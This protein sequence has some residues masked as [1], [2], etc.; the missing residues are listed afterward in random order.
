MKC[1]KCEHSVGEHDANGCQ[2]VDRPNSMDLVCRCASTPDGIE[3]DLLARIAVL[4]KMLALQLE[5]SLPPLEKSKVLEALYQAKAFV[6]GFED[7]EAQEGV[8]GILD[9][10][11]QAIAEVEQVTVNVTLKNGR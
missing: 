7:D 8:A 9:F 10:I 6:G 1:I 5:S 3:D 11:D 2:H 4:E